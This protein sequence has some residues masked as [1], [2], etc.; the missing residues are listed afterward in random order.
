MKVKARL[1]G[2]KVSQQ[3]AERDGQ[4]RAEQHRGKLLADLFGRFERKRPPHHRAEHD[5]PGISHS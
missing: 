1:S 4:Q 2:Q 5:Q 3:Q